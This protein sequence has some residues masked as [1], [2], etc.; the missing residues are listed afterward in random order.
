M[1]I[2]HLR[3]PHWLFLKIVCCLLWRELYNCCSAEDNDD[4]DDDDFHYESNEY[5]FARLLKMGLNL[6]SPSSISSI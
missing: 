6:V 5:R 2:R 1:G 3:Q 4:D